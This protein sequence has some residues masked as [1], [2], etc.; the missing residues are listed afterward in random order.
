[1]HGSGGGVSGGP[2]PPPLANSIFLKFKLPKI[3]LRHPPPLANS[4]SYKF[5]EGYVNKARLDTCTCIKLEWT[6]FK[7]VSIPLTAISNIT[8]ITEDEH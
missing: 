6:S 5:V 3:F 1:M 2:D 7:M 4:K 8:R